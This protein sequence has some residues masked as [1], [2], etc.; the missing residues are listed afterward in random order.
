ME[1]NVWHHVCASWSSQLGFWKI[2]KDGKLFDFD[3]WLSS[4]QVISGEMLPE[5]IVLTLCHSWVPQLS[6]TAESQTWPGWY[7]TQRNFF[8]CLNGYFWVVRSRNS[9]S[10]NTETNEAKNRIW[11]GKKSMISDE[12]FANQ[13][14]IKI[15]SWR[16]M[17]EADDRWR[18]THTST[19]NSQ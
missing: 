9:A 13:N 15:C 7:L 2:Y 14:R 5:E 8:F 12:R 1:R 3:R 10:L 17:C 4:E 11:T 16:C 6:A 18:W 19:S